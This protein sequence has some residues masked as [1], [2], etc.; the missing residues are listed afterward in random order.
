MT[1]DDIQSMEDAIG[2]IVDRTESGAPL[3]KIVEIANDLFGREEWY[4]VTTIPRLLVQ[5]ATKGRASSYVSQG[6]MWYVRA[7]LKES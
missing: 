7:R 2:H 5:F 4:D 3:S 1:Q 6:E